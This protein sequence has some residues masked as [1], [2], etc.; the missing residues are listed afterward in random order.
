MGKSA[1]RTHSLAGNGTNYANSLVGN[2]TNFRVLFSFSFYFLKPFS[3]FPF[4]LFVCLSF[5]VFLFQRNKEADT[6]ITSNPNPQTCVCT[7]TQTHVKKLWI[8]LKH[9]GYDSCVIVVCFA[10]YAAGVCESGWTVFADRCIKHVTR[11]KTFSQAEAVCRN[12][13]GRL[14]MLNHLQEELQIVS[15]VGLSAGEFGRVFVALFVVTV[16]CLRF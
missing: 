15:L 8:I 16:S 11:N 14:L 2:F 7:H 1:S 12:R 6:P 13:G 4:C 9:Y 3:F 5:L 10:L